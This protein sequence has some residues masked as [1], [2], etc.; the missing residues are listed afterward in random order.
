M[1][2]RMTTIERGQLI[3]A[4]GAAGGNVA[5]A[6]RALGLNRTTLVEKMRKLGMGGESTTES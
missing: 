1:R 4:L 6:A 2:A 5:Q 3:T